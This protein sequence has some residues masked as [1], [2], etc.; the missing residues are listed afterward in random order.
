VKQP[1]S[2]IIYLIEVASYFIYDLANLVFAAIYRLSKLE[3]TAKVT[4]DVVIFM[5]TLWKVRITNSNNH[6][7]IHLE[8]S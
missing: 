3:K 6:Y 4:P 5:Y 2:L 8:F 7:Q 1:T